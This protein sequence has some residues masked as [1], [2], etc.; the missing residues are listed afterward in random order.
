MADKKNYE[1]HSLS[2]KK[3]NK[4]DLDKDSET[5][6]NMKKVK[7]YQYTILRNSSDN[8]FNLAVEFESKMIRADAVAKECIK[9]KKKGLNPDLI[10]NHPGWGET[11]FIDEI[12]P[13]SKKIT[14]FEFYYNTKESDIDFDPETKQDDQHFLNTKL[15]ARNAPLILP[16]LTSNT[17][18]S[19]TNFQKSTAPNFLKNKI[20][21]IHDGIDTKKIKPGNDKAVI[22]FEYIDANDKK[23]KAELTKDNKIITF[24]N[25]NLE[26]Y[27]GYHSFMRA[28][29]HIQK[30]HPDSYILIIGGDSY[31][32]GAAP[33]SE[34]NNSSIAS[35]KKKYLD[36]VKKDLSNIENIIYTGAVSY[37]VFLSLLDLSS[38]HVY[39]TYPFV[40]SW[41]MLEAM[42]LEKVVVGSNTE[43]VKEVIVNNKN[44]LMVDFFDVKDIANKVNDV[45]SNPSK[46]NKI[47][48]AARK[49]IVE[50]Y[51]LET[52]S[53]PLQLKLIEE[54]LNE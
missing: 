47:R 18:I 20:K 16:Y 8:I 49:T 4:S 54:V 21:V 38:V 28:L 13:K 29:P 52:I 14:Y 46:F 1:V 12:W 23:R 39:L 22:N 25:R 6:K 27:R 51:D 7:H 44:G 45:L 11:I 5:F 50:G 34:D 33:K 43:P 10:I 19:P 40:L 24:V 37:N 26:P 2:W 41:S 3:I 42:A 15:M 48:K 31:S 32:Y 30:K 53:L 35:Y 9:L 36:E 17:L